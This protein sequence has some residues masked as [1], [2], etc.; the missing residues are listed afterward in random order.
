M[1]ETV[2]PVVTEKTSGAATPAKTP[3]GGGA[4]PGYD[5]STTISSLEDLKKKAP[6]VWKAM[7]EG[8]A[9]Q[10]T[11]DMQRSQERIKELRQSYEEDG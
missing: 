6:K 7:L 10:I 8:I 2:H 3:G 11:N 1:A 9:I 4:A 5:S